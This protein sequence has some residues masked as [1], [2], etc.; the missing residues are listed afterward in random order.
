[1]TL[2]AAWA[3]QTGLRAHLAADTGLTGLIGT[4]P[5]LYDHVPESAVFPLLTIG[6]SKIKPLDG[7]DRVTEHDVRLNAWSRWGGRP[8]A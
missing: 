1:M 3:L 4:P 5:R 2:P 7:D 6:E 8:G